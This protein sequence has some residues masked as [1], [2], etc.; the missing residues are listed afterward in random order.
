MKI[1]NLFRESIVR[2]LLRFDGKGERI[3]SL[4]RIMECFLQGLD[5]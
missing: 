1:L 4:V 3:N 2:G 5:L